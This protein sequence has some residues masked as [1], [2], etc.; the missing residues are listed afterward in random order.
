MQ[1]FCS[2][3]L[4]MATIDHFIETFTFVNSF[5]RTFSYPS[6]NKFI[7]L[8]SQEPLNIFLVPQVY[9]SIEYTQLP[10]CCWA[11]QVYCYNEMY[12]PY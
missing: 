2:R 8:S 11:Q 9:K 10:V 7:I 5:T 12:R 1:E 6:N 4:V 3:F